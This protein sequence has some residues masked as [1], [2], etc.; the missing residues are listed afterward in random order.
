[1]MSRSHRPFSIAIVLGCLLLLFAATSATAATRFAAPGGEGTDPCADPAKPCSIYTAADATAEETT[2]KAGDE[3]VLAPGLY[4]NFLRE[5]LGP[6][7]ELF[8]PVGIKLRGPATGVPATL[9]QVDSE[10]GAAITVRPNDV[11]SDVEVVSRGQLG[12]QMQGGTLERAFV[13]VE[14]SGAIACSQRRTSTI[15]NTVCLSRR[16]AEDGIAVG[17]DAVE[18]STSPTTVVSEL[19]NVTA[20]AL[21]RDSF[22]LR[23]IYSGDAVNTRH[24]Y[25][26]HANAVIASGRQTDVSAVANGRTFTPG[27]G[28]QVRVSLASSDFSTKSALST[29]PSVAGTLAEVSDPGTAGSITAEPRFRDEFHQAADS[30]TVDAGGAIPPAGEHDIDGNLRIL[31]AAPDIGADE[32][33]ALTTTVV[34]CSPATVDTRDITTC[35]ATV[36]DVSA[37]PTPPIGEVRFTLVGSSTGRFSNGGI[38]TLSPAGA[39]RASCLVRYAPTT[40][41]TRTHQIMA[42]YQGP[43]DRHE[44]SDS[45]QI[46]VTVTQGAE[47]ERRNPTASQLKC[48]P[49]ALPPGRVSTCTVTVEDISFD[50]AFP[51]S[52]PGGTV[53]FASDK[54]GEFSPR[55]CTLTPLPDGKASC[56]VDYTPREASTQHLVSANYQGETTHRGSKGSQLLTVATV[57]FAAP[58]GEGADPCA[59]PAAPC[60]LFTAAATNAPDTTIEPGAEVILAPGEYKS[61]A[62]DLGPAGSFVAKTDAV[63][64]GQVGQPRPVVN[65]D[66]TG[67]GFFSG[68][69]ATRGT[70]AHLEIVS[71][72]AVFNFRGQDTLIEDV[73]SRSSAASG[74]A[75]VQLVAGTM[76]DSACLASGAGASALVAGGL[77]G[78]V[79][80]FQLRN[81]TAIATGANS[82]G[83]SASAAGIP[84]APAPTMQL[85]A[86][87]VIA[88][89]TAADVKAESSSTGSTVDVSLD[90]SAFATRQTSV[91][92]S[93]GVANV[94]EPGSGTNITARARLAADGFHQ[95]SDSPTIDAGATDAPSGAFDIDGE[96]RT[97]GPAADVGADEF[98]PNPTTTALTCLPGRVTTGSPSTCTATV[99]DTAAN[100][101]SLAGDKV[102]FAVNPL[103]KGAFGQSPAQCTLLQAGPVGTATCQITYTPA[104]TVNNAIH[105]ITAS[106][107][108]APAHKA[109]SAAFQLTVRVG[110]GGG[111]LLAEEAG[112]RYQ[113]KLDNEPYKPCRPPFKV[114]KKL[115]KGRHVLRVRS[116]GPEG[117]VDPTVAVRR[118]TVGK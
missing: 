97:T 112:T 117:I 50:G 5:D 59:D 30:P 41:G 66:R 89:G 83:L 62:G 98:Q 94:T 36:T 24:S 17:V 18:E 40:V 53:E 69:E 52:S 46:F 110:G 48:A 58:G 29:A 20:I 44:S 38:C 71:N 68:L 103:G 114:K 101:T 60:S 22:G 42:S 63:V 25:I 16:T 111:P 65:L 3:V 87:A 37:A 23:Y 104:E 12:V 28:A 79:A 82:F 47:G 55:S 90:H 57:R 96:L 75:C 51:V 70:L 106:Y 99:T 45:K 11:V 14:F 73:I 9:W 93:G 35:T 2:I 108:P 56:R 84:G 49:G 8:L 39:N 33:A 115:K 80:S 92:G 113:C 81:V 85:D 54:G 118:W 74:T 105:T 1:M 34:D 26:V 4:Q 107:G 95:L 91:L 77:L 88:R 72:V 43:G 100:K 109:S 13:T 67:F 21:G 61:S 86:R 64:H 78:G 10:G 6:K 116:I 31:G 32:F 15:R 19:Q 7:G 76:R 102:T 27:S